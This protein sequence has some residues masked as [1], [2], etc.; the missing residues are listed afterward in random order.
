[1]EIVGDSGAT[2]TPGECVGALESYRLYR[3][4][5]A[6][7]DRQY[8]LQV[9]ANE[10][11]NPKMDRNAY[12]LELL[13]NRAAELEVW[14][15]SRKTAAD[16]G[17]CLNYDIT[18]PE[19]VESFTCAEQQDRT[20]NILGFK[21]VP[22]LSKLVPVIHLTKEDGVRVDRRTSA[23]MFGKVLKPLSLAHSMGIGGNLV[24]GYNFL[25]EPVEH[26]VMIFDWSEAGIHS[27]GPR[28]IP[29]ETRQNDIAEAARTVIVALGGN[30]R[31]GSFPEDRA[32]E[33][34]TKR[35][36]EYLLTLARGVEGNA[37]RAHGR[38][39]E[40]VNSI[41]PREYYPFTTYPFRG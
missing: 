38:F 24:S 39:Y 36:L 1:M 21:H 41:W 4:T 15:Q 8:L 11:Y 30:L 18:F 37:E 26:Y 23:W 6:E 20:I 10:T 3:C 34:D 25:I 35:Y 33:R 9:A 17:R 12:I 5:K 29:L 14:F 13:A 28:S 27:E 16:G 40:I 31:N 22:D 7:D 19:L 32:E 2:Y